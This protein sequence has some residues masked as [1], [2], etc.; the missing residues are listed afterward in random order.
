MHITN[1]KRPG[2]ILLIAFALIAM[3]V[4]ELIAQ[5]SKPQL[6]YTDAGSLNIIGKARNEGK[7]YHR[8]D[9]LKY[10]AVPASIKRLLS[11]PPGLAVSFRTNSNTIGVKWCTSKR[12]TQS[13]NTAIASEGLDL[14][15]KKEGRWQYAGVARVETSEC[16]EFTMVENMA[17][18]MKE[19]LLYLPIDD[20]LL[21]LSVGIDEKAQI[22]PAP[23]PFNHNILVYGS[24]IVHGSAA[25]RPGMTYPAILSRR[26]GLNF[27]NFGF[28]GNA[29]ME[30]E[31]ADMIS[32]L[33]VDAFILDCVPNTSPNLILQRTANLVKIIRA[34]HPG[35]PIIAIESIFREAGNF[36]QQVAAMVKEQNK[37]YRTEIEK[38]QQTDK[39]LY[40][41]GAGNFLGDDHEGSVDGAHPNDLGF[42]RMVDKLE[43]QLTAILSKYAIT[44]AKNAVQSAFTINNLSFLE[45]KP[46]FFYNQ[47]RG[48]LIAGNPGSVIVT[49]QELD[50]NVTHG[51]LDLYSLETTDGGNTWTK[52][53][54]I[55][56]LRRK[57]MPGGYELVMGDVYPVWHK[58]TN[59]VLATG[60]TFGF[61]NGKE[62]RRYE[63]VSYT[64][65]DPLSGKW[66]PLQLVKLPKADHE[67]RPFIEANAGCN[68]PYDLPDGDILLPIRYRK[69]STQRFYTTIVARCRFD[70]K[71]LKYIEHG[72]E[73]SI[74]RDRGLYE[75][76]VIGFKGKYYLTMRADHSAFVA[77]SD[78]GL[79]YGKLMEWTFDD[80]QVL[81]SYNT[82]Q[83]WIAQHDA[84]YLVYTRRGAN[85]DHIPRHRAPLFIAQV[86]PER[87]CVIRE[88]EQI[89]IPEN[90]A[91]LGAGFG[92][93]DISAN[94]TWV[95]AAETPVDR[96]K[97]SRIRLAKLQWI[98]PNRLFNVVEAAK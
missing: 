45:S 63:Q 29:K 80:G 90:N 49:A 26:T 39:D 62:N 24:S 59:K 32:D 68:Q 11:Y 31:V 52:P 5:E 85:N 73:F 38:L 64:V 28:G 98:K 22:E 50:P 72:T 15:I 9:T 97:P 8:L 40:M 70:G 19:C 14:Y 84:L 89:L 23:S 92:I 78:D 30:K 60:K 94:E 81:G 65:Y 10:P 66:G 67:G 82:Q 93:A 25:T 16:N 86:D 33:P 57:R 7:L 83:H 12:K 58:K 88:S 18:G 2:Y 95:F 47:T 76:S 3:P 34:R 6:K 56:S 48:A 77:A 71:T 87:L 20:E 75:P 46:G 55:E 36:N 51:F 4:S 96:T 17:D 69:D 91:D 54:V 61:V 27:I 42:R 79:H 13:S 37:N 21:S 43:P 35:K 53:K 41:I 1:R 44:T 74:D